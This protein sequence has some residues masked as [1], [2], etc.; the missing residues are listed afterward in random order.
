M[1]IKTKLQLII[2]LNVFL[3]A[4]V[5]SSSLL[6]HVRADRQFEKQD[7][8]MEL[9]QAIFEKSQLREE[10]FMYRGERAKEQWLLMHKK[11]GVLLEK[12]AGIFAT[13]ENKTRVNTIIR[14]HDKIGYFFTELVRLDESAALHRDSAQALRERIV[15]QM[16]MSSTSQYREGLKLLKAVH[17]KTLYQHD[18][19]HLYSNVAFGFMT[20]VIVFLAAVIIRSIASPLSRL[21]R[22]VEIVAAGN[23]DYKTDLGTSDELGDLSEAFDNMAENLKKITVSRD[24]LSKEIARREQVEA[25][26]SASQTMLQ[27]VIDNI[28][29]RVFWKD[30]NFRYIGCNAPFL[31]DAG[32][33][34]LNDIAGKEDFELSW[35]ETA[36]IYRAD[37]RA[38]MESDIPRINYEEPQD[39]PDGTRRWLRTSKIPLHDKEDNVIGVLGTYE[40]ITDRKLAEARLITAMTDLERSNKDLEQFAY[41]ASHDLQEPLRMVSSYTQLL[42]QHYEGRLDEKAKKFMDYAVDGAVRM[43]RL[44]NDLLAYSRVGTKG[45]ALETT[46]THALLGEAIRSLAAAIEEKRALI[47]N[48]DLPTVRADAS[49]LT[50][51]FQ[52]LLANGIKFQGENVPHLHVSARDQRREWV[53]SVRDNGIGIERQYADR[54]FTIFQRLYTRQEY[55]GTGIGLALCKR[56]VERHGGRIWF[57][58]EPGQG[59]TFFFTIPK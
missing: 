29:Q 40:D 33:A 6:W 46:D 19:S 23:L 32:L 41:V 54:V 9:N 49:Q 26:L 43:Q 16:L 37:D 2:I 58:S 55:P 31:K 11:I 22:G 4:G 51:V 25:D 48:D 10:Y 53:F 35:K 39:K 52:N 13:P 30:R 36:P 59:S 14:L 38:V 15:T 28:P 27:L 44:I 45:K 7:M 5:V 1:K 42:A 17:E 50:Q 18:I 20:L 56:I 24:D 12:M 47:T 21:Q 57:E 34:E 8:V 3:L